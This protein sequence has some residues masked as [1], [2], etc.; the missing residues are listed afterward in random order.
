MRPLITIVLIAAALF[1]WERNGFDT[2]Q[3]ITV[4]DGFVF[5]VAQ[6]DTEMPCPVVEILLNGAPF[7]IRN[8]VIE[9]DG[10]FQL[11]FNSNNVPAGGYEMLGASLQSEVNCIGVSPGTVC[12]ERY[13]AFTQQ[14][15]ADEVIWPDSV[16]CE[17][18]YDV[19]GDASPST[20]PPGKVFRARV[21]ARTGTNYPMP[22]ST[23]VGRVVEFDVKCFELGVVTLSWSASYWR[24]YPNSVFGTIGEG[25]S[26]LI[27]IDCQPAGSASPTPAPNQ[28]TPTQT[29]WPAIVQGDVN[30]DEATNAVD[31]ALLLQHSAGLLPSLSC[32][33]NADINGDGRADAIDA[34]LIL[35]FAAGLVSWDCLD[36]Y[37]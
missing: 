25:G 13:L 14:E 5:G 27:D 18:L 23:F 36:G 2:T 29:P 24:S 15:C 28:P 21:D 33:Q 7:N 6:G 11:V 10:E 32:A 4:N 17:N 9:G 35:Q 30:C 8:C 37:C 19:V 34:A 16:N 12:Q 20:R 31:A 22:I 3:A 26:G 1:A